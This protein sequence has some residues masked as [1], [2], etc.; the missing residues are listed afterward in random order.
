MRVLSRVAGENEARARARG[1]KGIR[2]G[3]R[4]ARNVR[5]RIHHLGNRARG[6]TV[7]IVRC[8][9]YTMALTLTNRHA[10]SLKKQKRMA[11]DQEKAT[12]QNRLNT[13]H[14]RAQVLESI[15]SSYIAGIDSVTAHLAGMCRTLAM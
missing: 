11:L 5:Q 13:V 6:S 2:E 12:H 1:S 9:F 3:P 7:C 10:L 4:L 8:T 15:Q 14:H